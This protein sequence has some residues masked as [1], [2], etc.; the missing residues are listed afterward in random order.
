MTFV[1]PMADADGHEERQE[2]FLYVS[3]AGPALAFHP[4]ERPA[5]KQRSPKNLSRLAA[6]A[7]LAPAPYAASLMN[8]IL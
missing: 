4:I 7:S 8:A 5:L 3:T 1:G 6:T 2:A